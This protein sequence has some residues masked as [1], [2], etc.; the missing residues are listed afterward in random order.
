MGSSAL[1]DATENI[2]KWSKEA[3]KP[4]PRPNAT[5]IFGSLTFGD[6]AQRRRLPRDTYR[7]LRRTITQGEPLDASNADII[8]SAMKDWA[9]EHGA[10]HYTHWFQPLTGITAEKHDAFI[11]QSSEGR[12]VAEFRKRRHGRVGHAV[13]KHDVAEIAPCGLSLEYAAARQEC[14]PRLGRILVAPSRKVFPACRAHGRLNCGRR[15]FDRLDGLRGGNCRRL[16]R[17]DDHRFGRRGLASCCEHQRG[18]RDPASVRR[19]DSARCSARVDH[20]INGEKYSADCPMESL[21]WILLEAGLALAAL[22]LIVWWTWPKSRPDDAK[23]PTPKDP[24]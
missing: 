5:E 22:I 13:R 7:A 2:I 4:A 10:T 18:G 19:L 1:R 3:A 17:S 24:Q 21:L 9:I 6:E 12:G 8:A 20:R 16:G 23:N 15:G 14:S 11:A